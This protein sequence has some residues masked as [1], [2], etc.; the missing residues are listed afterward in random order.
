MSAQFLDDFPHVYVP[1]TSGQ[2]WLALHGTGGNEHDLVPLAKALDPAAGILSP[3]GRVL[4]NGM[5][6]FFRRLAEGVFDEEDL[7]RRA[8]ELSGFIGAASVAYGFDSGKV[9]ALG[10]SNGAN[11]A[12]ALL[13]LHPGILAGAALL[14]PMVPIVP[15]MLPDL[16]GCPV[17]VA[18]GHLDPIVPV[19]NARRLVSLLRDS[20]ANVTAR[21]ENAGHGLTD[22]TVNATKLWLEGIKS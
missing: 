15:G 20:G 17:L 11:I 22:T 8:A 16:D 18:A 1:G 10:Y 4:E 21:F 19:E 2:I 7:V 3:R 6:R 13:L 12:G 5:P 9:V 14:R